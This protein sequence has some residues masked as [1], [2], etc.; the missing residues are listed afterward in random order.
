MTTI[1]SYSIG[2]GLDARSYIDS[3]KLTR[4]E[5]AKLTRQINAARDPAEKFNQAQTL[6]NHALRQGGIDEKIYSRLLAEATAKRDKEVAAIRRQLSAQQGLNSATTKGASAFGQ[7]GSALASAFG[8]G[9]GAAAALAGINA[10]TR[11]LELATDAAIGFASTSLQEA[12]KLESLGITYKGLLGGAEKA[13]N[14]LAELQQFTASTPFQFDEVNKAGASLL[15]AGVS[16]DNLKGRLRV[17][18]NVAAGTGSSMSEMARMTARVMQSGKVGLEE[19]EF[20]TQRNIS[21][22]SLLAERLGVSTKEVMKLS[23]QGKLN[24]SDF[25]AIL[26]HLGGMQGKFGLAMVEQSQT[27]EGRL[28]TLRDQYSMIAAQVGEKMLPAAQRFLDA[29]D[30]G[31]RVAEELLGTTGGLDAYFWAAGEAVYQM[32][33]GIATAVDYAREFLDIFEQGDYIA[34]GLANK[35][36]RGREAAARERAQRGQDLARM[37]A[38][39]EKAAKQGI[40]KRDVNAVDQSAEAK[41]KAA[42]KQFDT[43]KDNLEKLKKKDDELTRERMKLGADLAIARVRQEG[44]A[45]EAVAEAQ[46]KM[47][48]EIASGVTGATAENDLSY[49]RKQESERIAAEAAQNFRAERG[50]DVEVDTSEGDRIN[51][52]IEQINT[53]QKELQKQQLE[54]AKRMEAAQRAAAPI[55]KA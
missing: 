52:R 4:S 15:N 13:Q 39:R 42:Q 55:K 6:L 9:G 17:L 33:H 46:K 32:V 43:D 29:I 27:L 31:L 18:G 47:Q 51:K 53:E 23:S 16:V 28:S 41:A 7:A 30:G 36:E 35:L 34:D 54:V 48:K 5:T 21:A 1:N 10:I 44:R 11:A 20:L 3:A 8:I 38:E 22:Y 19:I 25:E 45:T 24:A 2:L 14:A 40:E 49:M 12:G 50:F 26:D 37:Q